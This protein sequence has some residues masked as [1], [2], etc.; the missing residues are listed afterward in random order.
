MSTSDVHLTLGIPFTSALGVK[1][2]SG[3]LGV[4]PWPNDSCVAV[5]MRILGKA[6]ELLAEPILCL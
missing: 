5:G 2:T 1:G 3:D 6:P 4:T